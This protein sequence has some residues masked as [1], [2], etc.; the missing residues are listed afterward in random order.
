MVT[1]YYHYIFHSCINGI[2]LWNIIPQPQVLA[3]VLP[4]VLA[5]V[6]AQVLAQVLVQVHVVSPEGVVF[7]VVVWTSMEVEQDPSF[8]Q[9]WVFQPVLV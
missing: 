2:P 7:W 8:L 3:R 5:Q 6:P 1:H 9:I 4:Q